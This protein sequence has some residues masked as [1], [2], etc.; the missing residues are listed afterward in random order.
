MRTFDGLTISEV[1]TVNR[2]DDD[3]LKLQSMILKR[4]AQAPRALADTEIG[5]G[6]RYP[7]I[8]VRTV[9]ARMVATGLI[10]CE[11]RITTDWH[12]IE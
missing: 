6:W 8:E 1:D 4:L 10:A 7:H 12:G 9:L 3:V 11:R 5:W 2:W